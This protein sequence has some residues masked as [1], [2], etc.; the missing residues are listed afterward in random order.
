[1]AKDYTKYN[2]KGLGENLNKR[3]LV[4]TVV[5]DWAS[6]KNPSF[7]DMQSTF[8]EEIQG[9]KGFIVKK[10]DVTDA[11]RFNM[12][13]PLSIKG[14]MQVVVSNQ[15]G[16][17]NIVAF[18]DL[19]KSLGYAVR[20]VSSKSSNGAGFSEEDIAVLTETNSDYEF[21]QALKKGLGKA[22]LDALDYEPILIEIATKNTL[23][24]QSFNLSV[25]TIAGWVNL[26]FGNLCYRAYCKE[27]GITKTNFEYAATWGQLMTAL[28]ERAETYVDYI[29]MASCI[30]MQFT[31]FEDKEECIQFAHENYKKAIEVMDDVQDLVAL[32]GGHLQEEYYEN[33]ELTTK[34]GIKALASASTFQDFAYICFDDS[35]RCLFNNTDIYKTAATKAVKLKGQ[36]DEYDIEH[37]KRMLEEWED[38]ETLKLL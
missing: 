26:H 25:A 2:V 23:Q 15:W 19:A 22:R 30:Q 18:L 9:S 17:K 10:N 20:P 34:A 35:E 13:E 37:F 4:F 8:P 14:G 33:E 38:Q 31:A 27:E 36:A 12:Q 29:N 11:Q 16:T 24:G 5:K 6:N 3:H 32:V 7:E 1:M 21:D 28:A